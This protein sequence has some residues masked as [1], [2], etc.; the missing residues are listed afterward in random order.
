MIYACIAAGG[1]G[2]HVMPG[3]A[4]AHELVARGHD[5]GTIVFV[6]SERGIET[7]LV[8]EAGFPLEV[9]PG[10][11]IERKVSLAA[12]G[13][14]VG[15]V[16]GVLRGIFLVR[17]LRPRIVVVCGGYASV[18]SIVGA[19]LWRV[20]MVVIA[21]DARAGAADRLAARFAKA[22]A[23]PFADT[24]LP[25]AV[26]TGNP[27]RAEVLAVDRDRDRDAARAALDL[28]GDR[29]VVGVYTGSLGSRRVNDAVQGLAERW[30]KRSDVAIR[31][32]IGTR[33]WDEQGIDLRPR[34]A[35]A[36]PGGLVYQAVRY[37]DHIERLLAAS[38]VVVSRAGGAT[39]AELAV[40][41]VPSVLVPL[42]I[43]TRDHQTANAEALVRVGAA[44]RVPDD[45]LDTDRLEL[46]LE[47][48]VGDPE[49]RARMAA[50]AR[51]QAHPDAAQR[52]TDLV[53]E[54]ARP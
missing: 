32:V 40:A 2:G 54:H 36:E 24:D 26:V 11:G 3:L 16:R 43:A 7:R 52:V 19:V 8:P 42:P 27:V 17:R 9:L 21:R 10:R 45:E 28:P 47:P 29:V 34:P 48:L 53:E 18:P 39:V 37:E 13:A 4:V 41:G 30:A 46:E 38:D 44:V 5:A 14:I 25:R 23:V 12:L 1:T 51:T 31:H 49:R 33:D 6:G 15:I 50:A 20:P 22:S 35:D